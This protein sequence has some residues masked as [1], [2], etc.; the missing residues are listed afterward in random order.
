MFRL[1]GVVLGVF[2]EGPGAPF[3]ARLVVMMTLSRDFG[4]F[5]NHGPQ[6]QH[7]IETEE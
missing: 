6:H 3:G 7:E 4:T 2:V 1:G 5:A